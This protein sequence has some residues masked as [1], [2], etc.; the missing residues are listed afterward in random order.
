MEPRGFADAVREV[1]RGGSALDPEVVAQM[2]ERRH[3]AARSTGSPRASGT[4][5]AG[6]AE[7]RSNSAIATEL[8][9]SET[10]LQ[11]HITS[12][13][14]KLDLPGTPKATV[15]CSPS[16]A[17]SAR[18]ATD[19]SPQV[20]SAAPPRAEAGRGHAC[21]LHGLPHEQAARFSHALDM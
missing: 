1:A 14:G 10:T 19:G 6:M 9:I 12:I 15:G 8:G 18:R 11:R 13:F 20:R 4:A 2:L 21:V 5:L 16:S 17:T 7:G 3:P